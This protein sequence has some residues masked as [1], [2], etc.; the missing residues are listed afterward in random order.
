MYSLL[1]FE[2]SWR[3][4]ILPV[5][6]VP[7]VLPEVVIAPSSAEVNQEPSG[8][9]AGTATFSGAWTL[10]AS[11]P[12]SGAAVAAAPCAAARASA[13]FVRNFISICAAVRPRILIVVRGRLGPARRFW[14]SA[15][16]HR[17]RPCG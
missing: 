6:E 4:S 2:V 12:S 17:V 1:Q 3:A 16:A 14:S 9:W 7:V 13:N 5:T 15:G 11:G 8:S 10:M